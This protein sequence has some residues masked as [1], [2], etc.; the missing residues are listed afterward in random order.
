MLIFSPCNL[1]PRQCGVNRNTETGFCGCGSE[2]KV[3]RAALHF[4]EEP[5][6]SGRGGSGTVFFS[7]CNLGCVYCQNDEISRGGAGKEVSP[8]RLA[9]IFLKLQAQGAH[10]INLVTATPHLPGICRALDIAKPALH[11]PVVYNCGGYERAETIRA[12]SGYVD[13]YLPDIKYFSGE[14]SKRYSGAADYFSV[15]SKAVKEM[16]SQAGA[17]EYDTE[18]MLR[19]G[20]LIR[21]LVLPGARKDSMAIL[22]WL[23]E[24]L[25]KGR[26][27]LA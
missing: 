6:V 20:V 19:R 9:E 3:A 5:C 21:H 12:L 23:A 18:G 13:V 11:I 7:G 24:E 17:L 1:C 10:N 26:Y 27:L 22:Q 2:I 16:V 4:W 25:P 14:L 15:A 8:E